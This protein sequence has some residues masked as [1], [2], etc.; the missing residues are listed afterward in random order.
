MTWEQIIGLVGAVGGLIAT[1]IMPLIL[2]LMH[3]ARRVRGEAFQRLEALLRHLDEC[4]ETKTESLR[5][6]ING[7]HIEVAREYVTR[8]EIRNL[9]VDLRAEI[10]AGHRLRRIEDRIGRGC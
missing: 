2:F 7:I 9:E 8:P 4:I 1:V 6:Q 10:D 5:N 3:Q